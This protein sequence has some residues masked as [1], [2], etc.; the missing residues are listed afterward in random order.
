MLLEEE[1]NDDERQNTDPRTDHFAQTPVST[2][3]KLLPTRGH[4]LLGLSLVTAGNRESLSHEVLF[5]SIT[6]SDPHTAS[7]NA[8]IA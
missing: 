3:V 4:N 1:K 7:T 6:M 8:L 5:T 2:V